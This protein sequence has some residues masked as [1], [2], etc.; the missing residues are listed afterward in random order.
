M[1]LDIAVWPLGGSIALGERCWPAWGSS[2]FPPGALGLSQRGMGVR[3]ECCLC[4][5]SPLRLVLEAP[6][7]PAAE[8]SV[9]TTSLHLA[10][11]PSMVPLSRLLVFY[12]RENGEGV[13]DSLQFTV[14]T[15]FENQVDHRD[16]PG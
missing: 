4:H 7:A 3:A 11:T 1:I 5:L 2:I 6:P 10:V 12:V 16:L 8:L 13:A 15:F 9:C 14:E